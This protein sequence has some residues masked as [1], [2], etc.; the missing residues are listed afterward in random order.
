MAFLES[1]ADSRLLLLAAG[2][3]AFYLGY[4]LFSGSRPQRPYQEKI[5]K[6]LTADEFKV[7]GRFE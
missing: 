4:R 1:F 5:N 7:K 3:V 6:I 2:L